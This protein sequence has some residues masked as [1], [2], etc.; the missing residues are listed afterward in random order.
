MP[1]P[2]FPPAGLVMPDPDWGFKESPQAKVNEQELGDGYV[3]REPKGLNHIKRTF[4]MTWSELDEQVAEAAYDW[5]LPKLKLTPIRIKHPVR[6]TTHQV[7]IDSL[8]I[9]Y[10][11]YNNAVLNLTVT[12]DFNPVP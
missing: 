11:T 8:D 5:L 12:E 4:P 1:A 10:D 6:G 9:T 2:M 7:V 3:F